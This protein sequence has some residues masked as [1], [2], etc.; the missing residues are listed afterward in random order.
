M[1]PVVYYTVYLSESEKIVAFGTA[2]ECAKTLG[3]NK[4]TFYST[5]CHT[6]AGDTSKYEFEKE[7]VDRAEYEEF[8]NALFAE[9][10]KAMGRKRYARA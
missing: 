10:I 5:V 9:K 1:K 2:A 8:K 6:R 3:M 4:D 7:N